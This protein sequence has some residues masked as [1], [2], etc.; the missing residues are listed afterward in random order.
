[1]IAPR[2]LDRA[3]AG[4]GAGIAEEHLVGEGHRDEPLRQPLL[5]F[6]A[7]EVRR[8]PQLAGLLGQRRDEARVRMPERVDGDAGGEI[9]IPV[10]VR[11]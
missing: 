4:L 7:I 10:A 2:G 6:D 9:E 11:P 3:L 8:V 5:P 1:M